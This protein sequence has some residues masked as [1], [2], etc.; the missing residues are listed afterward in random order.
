MPVR[1]PTAEPAVLVPCP[2]DQASVAL[3]ASRR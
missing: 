2:G 3:S 1:R